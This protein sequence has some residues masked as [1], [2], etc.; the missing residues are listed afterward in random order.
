MLSSP[1]LIL[2]I[3]MLLSPPVFYLAHRPEEAE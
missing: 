1:W 2:L 3:Y